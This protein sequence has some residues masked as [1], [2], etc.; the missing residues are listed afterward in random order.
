MSE[1]ES[2]SGSGESAPR[3]AVVITVSDSCAEGSRRDESGPAVRREL[4][5]QGFTV[6][7]QATVADDQR[8]IEELLRHA[9]AEAALVV[10]T[11]G[12]GIAAADVTPEATRSVCDRLLEGVAELMRSEGRRDT[13]L[14]VLSRGLCGTRGTALILNLPGSPAGAVSSLRAALP[15]L[16]HALDLLSGRTEHRRESAA[17]TEPA[18]SRGKVE[19]A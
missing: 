15:V 17:K 9:A 7:R 10:T 8:R 12:T 14:A 19:R 1:S 13:P 11:G 16:P 5:A 18:L 4:E 6:V 2:G 3:T